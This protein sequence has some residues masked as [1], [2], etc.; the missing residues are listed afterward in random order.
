MAITRT[1]DPKQT[2]RFLVLGTVC[3]VVAALSFAQEVLVPIALALLLSFLLAP[4]VRLLERARLPRVAA[5]IL[6]VLLAFGVLSGIGFVVYNQLADLTTQLPR[7]AANVQKKVADM[8][9]PGHPL[10]WFHHAREEATKLVATPQPQ[11]T[12]RPTS[13]PANAPA[14]SSSAEALGT[15]AGDTLGQPPSPPPASTDRVQRVEV[16]NQA[17]GGTSPLSVVRS[18]AGEVLGPVGTAFIVVVFTIFM[19]LQRED[20]RDRIIRL[21]GRERLTTT[22]EA[23]NDAAERVSRYLLLQSIVNG[24]VG[25]IVMSLLWGEGKVAGTPFPS[26]ALWGLLATLLRFIPYV[27]IWISALVPVLLSLA[28]FAGFKWTVITIGL[29]F[30]T[31]LVTANAVEPMLFGSS[32]GIGTLAVLVAA[33]FWTWL[34]GPVGLLLSTPLTVC[35]VVMGKYVPALEFLN[36]LLSDE[37][38]LSPP[39]RVYQ[40]LLAGDQEEAADLV[41]EYAK[42]M[43]LEELYDTVMLPALAEAEGD[44]HHG[45]MPADR[46][47]AIRRGV[48]DVVDELGDRLKADAAKAAGKVEAPAHGTLAAAPPGTRVHLPPGCV[49]NVV[50]L[51]AHDDT[52]QLAAT[53]LGQLLGARGYCVT[54]LSPTE[55][56]SEMVAAVE[57]A[58]PD[59]VIVSALPPGAVTHARYLCK[60]LHGKVPDVQLIIG[61]WT[62]RRDLQQV[63]ERIACAHEVQ[64]AAGLRQAIG[65]LHEI[66]APR[67]I[68][69]TMAT[70]RGSGSTT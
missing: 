6:S 65:Q 22:T 2:S 59:V 45:D 35:L 41:H 44:A 14:P 24:T 46:R 68:N 54:V 60:R 3:V 7:Y 20:L 21:V 70:R 28:V 52:D 38:A 32:T 63:R 18:V 47:A 50:C 16:V 57:A 40:R 48:A 31:E 53:M 25:V 26:P 64:L 1:A 12:S 19:L 29:Y 49:L 56:A 27:G 23:L 17:Q 51:P 62:V 5:V 34:W 15:M 33:A 36:V 8:N 67:I 55:L 11:P 69:A 37:P 4:L 61:L 58:K 39:D 10:A 66:V 42:T 13:Q 9:Q 30:V 43:P